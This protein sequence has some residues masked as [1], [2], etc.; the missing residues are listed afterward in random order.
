M[1]RNQTIYNTLTAE[2]NPVVLT[3]EDETSRH[4]VPAGIESHFKVIAVAD[5][6]SGLSRVQRH[7]VVHSLLMDE[8]AKGLHALSLHLY[9]P[10]EWERQKK[11]ANSPA[12]RDGWKNDH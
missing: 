2:L 12:C 9:T 3:V 4:H 7:R 10:S 6:F 1:S 11:V 5:H 8:F